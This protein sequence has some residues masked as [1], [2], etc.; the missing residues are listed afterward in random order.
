MITDIH[1]TSVFHLEEYPAL[2]RINAVCFFLWL[3]P[4]SFAQLHTGLGDQ[5]IIPFVIP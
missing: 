3:S 2:R 1:F 5:A 4:V